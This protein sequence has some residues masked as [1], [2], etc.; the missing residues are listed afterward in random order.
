MPSTARGANVLITD[1]GLLFQVFGQE[2]GADGD[3]LAGAED[4]FGLPDGRFATE[5][6]A[7]RSAEFSVAFDGANAVDPVGLD[8]SA[9]VFNYLLGDPADWRTNVPSYETVAYPGLYA[10]IDLY[11]WGRRD[12]LKYEFHVAPGADY[13]DI[14]VSYDG[15]GGLW[16]DAGGALHIETEL[17][18]LIDDA[19]YIYQEIAGERTDVAGA[20]ELIDADTYAFSISGEYDPSAELIIDPYLMWST[21]L[22]GSNA[23]A[24]VAIAVDSVGN[25]LVAGDTSS[26]GWAFGG[27]DTTL[28][29][30][31]PS[32]SWDGFVAK[33]GEGS[34]VLGDANGDGVAN[35]ADYTIWSGNYLLQPVPAWLEGGWT[36][37]NFNAD[38]IVDDADYTIWLDSISPVPIP[39]DA[40]LDGKVDVF[41]LA[42][43]G[44]HYNLP[45]PWDWEHADFTGD[46]LVDVFDLGIL[47]NNYGNAGA[48]QPVPEPAA[49]ALLGLGGMALLRRKRRLPKS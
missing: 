10:G 26:P 35:M 36:F 34:P 41:D 22:G 17:G 27:F 16:L 19:P 44:N 11:T 7:M 25:V 21:Y 24:A 47:G 42:I 49:L 2:P 37:A 20:F 46:G 33:I 38:D 30:P 9:S 29:G 1:A 15:I 5:Q 3:G 12:G 31:A 40:D 32:Y 6:A 4:T 14:Q 23:D 45:G 43:L 48:G 8:P 18:E 28:G 13:R 39:G